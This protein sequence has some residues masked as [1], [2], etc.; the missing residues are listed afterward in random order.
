[1]DPL[2]T[3]CLR[4]VQQQIR[5]PDRPGE[6][7]LDGSLE[8]ERW[9]DHDDEQLIAELTRGQGNGRWTA[10]MFLIFFMMRRISAGG[11][12]R[13]A[14]PMGLLTTTASRSRS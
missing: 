10:E 3:A 2:E 13:P 11:R 9:S 8:I 12:H 1:M 4:I 5:L 7:F 6:H 14:A